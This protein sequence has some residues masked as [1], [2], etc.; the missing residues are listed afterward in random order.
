MPKETLSTI[1]RR[2]KE[3]EIHTKK[4]R[5]DSPHEK[6]Y[7]ERPQAH[8][9]VILTRC[10]QSCFLFV[11]KIVQDA[12]EVTLGKFVLSFQWVKCRLS[13]VYE[14]GIDGEDLHMF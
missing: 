5:T 2:S 9:R 11:H 8:F 7:C 12:L 14:L 3:A 10:N 4:L 1:E 6:H 13:G